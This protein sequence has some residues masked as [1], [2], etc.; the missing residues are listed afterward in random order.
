MGGYNKIYFDNF[1][2]EYVIRK[3]TYIR[4]YCVFKKAYIGFFA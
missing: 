4:E 3:R 2:Y 1:I